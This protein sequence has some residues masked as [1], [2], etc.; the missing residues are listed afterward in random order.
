VNV[1]ATPERC[2]PDDLLA[3]PDAKGC[4]LVDGRLVEKQGGGEKGYVGGRIAYLLAAFLEAHPVGL[5]FISE[6]GYQCFPGRRLVRKPDVS[7][8]RRGRLPGDRPPRG[9]IRVAPDLAAE[10]VSPNDTYYEVDEKVSEYLDAGVP[11]VWVVNPQARTVHVYRP[12]GTAVRLRDGQELS[13]EP[14]LPGFRCPVGDLVPP[15]APQ[16]PEPEAAPGP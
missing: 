10:V 14:V 2:S 6:A 16:T 5:P 3:L 1:L 11:L 9:H 12:D 4:E 13:G 7:F 15:P 8:V